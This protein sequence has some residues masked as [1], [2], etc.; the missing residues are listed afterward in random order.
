MLSLRPNKGSRS[1]NSVVLPSWVLSAVCDH[2]A[3]AVEHAQATDE[4]DRHR[5]A[6]QH[7]LRVSARLTGR[8]SVEE[9]LFA[10]C[11][12]IREALGFQRVIVALTE[13]PDHRLM[14][15]SSIGWS[16]DE[17]AALPDVPVSSIS[18]NRPSTTASF[19]SWSSL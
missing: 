18:R 4:V 2:A 5:A 3:L 14:I 16:T 13:G 7:L 17:L 6:V 9:M 12:G 1:P 19:W 15:R 10:V 11:G 8:R